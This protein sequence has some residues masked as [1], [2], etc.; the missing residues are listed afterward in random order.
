LA[1]ARADLFLD[2]PWLLCRDGAAPEALART[3]ALVEALGA[4]AVETN[5]ATHDR[6]VALT[7]HLPQ[8]LAS[9]L[10]VQVAEAQAG[11]L[12]GSGF[13]SMTRTAGGPADIWRDIF[14][15]N[16]DEVAA[17]AASLAARLQQLAEDLRREP[18]ELKRVLALLEQARRD[19]SPPK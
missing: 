16:A 13:R 18:P 9:A 12:A 3:V 19:R 4:V 2:A 17:A 11:E 8:L 15:S 10:A 7:S 14:S 1:Q 6:A 5:A